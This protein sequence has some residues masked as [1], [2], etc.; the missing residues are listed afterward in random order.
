MR[1]SNGLIWFLLLQQH[2]QLL[3]ILVQAAKSLEWHYG[4][5]SATNGNG[6]IG[7]VGRPRV[8]VHDLQDTGFRNKRRQFRYGLWETWLLVH[9]T[10]S[11]P[12]PPIQST[13]CWDRLSG[14]LPFK[15]KHGEY[16]NIIADISTIWHRI[17]LGHHCMGPL[18]Y[19]SW[20]W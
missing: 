16:W 8:L 10:D 2:W 12:C 9:V 20:H 11:I 14:T 1:T 19:E 18:G 17:C 4:W 7:S 5:N 3:V 13:G 15:L 6:V